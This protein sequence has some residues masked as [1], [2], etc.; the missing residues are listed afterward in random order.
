MNTHS[1]CYL[2]NHDLFISAHATASQAINNL[3]TT[4]NV[5]RALIRLTSV[6][7]SLSTDDGGKKE[8]NNFYHPMGGT[9]DKDKELCF[10]M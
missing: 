3:N 6:Y 4:V 2:V 8:V 1:I 5:S 7:V 9:Y 10:E